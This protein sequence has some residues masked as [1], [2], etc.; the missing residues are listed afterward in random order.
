MVD[1]DGYAVLGM[2]SMKA[3]QPRV[4]TAGCVLAAALGLT[5]LSAGCASGGST[6][7]SPQPPSTQQ[8]SSPSPGSDTRALAAAYLAIALPANH[9]LETEVDGFKVHERDNLAAAESD[10]RAQAATE[11]WFD[12]RVMKIPFPQQ[13]A[14]VVRALVRANQSRVKLTELQ[15]RST[16][17]AKLRSFT[18]RHKAADAAVEVQV[19]LIRRDLG[20]PPPSTS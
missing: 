12:Q 11:R 2:P 10:L 3:R 16:S 13:I 7:P 19:K 18:S 4:A 15:A 9:R 6:G 8:T 5:I 17:I 1:P 20:L 14:A